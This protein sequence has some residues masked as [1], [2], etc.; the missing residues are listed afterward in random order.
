MPES[1]LWFSACQPQS[2]SR[3]CP[4]HLLASSFQARGLLATALTPCI[5]SKPQRYKGS[6]E[7]GRAQGQSRG[8]PAAAGCAAGRDSGSAQQHSP[9]SY[10]FL[11]ASLLGQGR[12]APWH[13]GC[14]N[15]A[16]SLALGFLM[17]TG[18][19]WPWSPA[20]RQRWASHQL[21]THELKSLVGGGSRNHN[22][23]RPWRKR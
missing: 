20:C 4:P 3:L 14:I 5:G 23:Q 19:K 16:A 6:S 2:K 22:T 8:N 15:K 18:S 7:A 11:M 21:W 17:R 1:C 13:S 10:G 9:S 12:G